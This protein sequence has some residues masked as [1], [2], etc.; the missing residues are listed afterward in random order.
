V[1]ASIATVSQNVAGPPSAGHQE[2]LTRPL[3]I[4]A[5]GTVAAADHHVH[6]QRASWEAVSRPRPRLA[7][8]ISTIRLG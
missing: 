8:V 2:R 5:G 1:S 3:I 6:A 7:P 4:A